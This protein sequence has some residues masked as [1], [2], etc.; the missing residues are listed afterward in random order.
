MAVRKIGIVDLG[1]NNISSL[2]RALQQI[3]PNCGIIEVSQDS[4]FDRA[5][6][7]FLPGVGNFG[8]AT[9]ALKLHD[10]EES[11]CAYNARGKPLVAIC[12]GM[13]LLFESSDESPTSNG[14]ALLKGT[15]RKLPSS[16]G[17]PV[18]NVGWCEVDFLKPEMRI[19]EKS[20][21]FYFTHSYYVEPLDLDSVLCFSKH[22]D[23]KF[24]SG[25]KKGN[26]MGFQFHPEKSGQ[27]GLR[28]LARSISWA[29]DQV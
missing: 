14:L 7:L 6:L 23:F 22:G 28:L 15:V 1:I 2:K 12:L 29:E 19:L 17:N 26:L 24:A 18:P 9:K 16:P 21:D 5:D 10:V 25:V 3:Q 8:A 11:L 4:D 13:Q 20:R 27:A